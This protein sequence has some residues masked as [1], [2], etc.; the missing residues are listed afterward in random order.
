MD[1]M[2]YEFSSKMQELLE[3]ISEEQVRDILIALDMA[4]RIFLIGNGGSQAVCSH[5]ANDFFKRLYT[6]GFSLNSDALITCLANDYGFENMYVEWLQRF[7][8]TERDVVIAL[9]SSGRSPDITKVVDKLAAEEIDVIFICGFSGPEDTTFYE[10]LLGNFYLHFD[11]FNYGIVEM[12]T[13]VFLHALVEQLV[14]MEGD[15]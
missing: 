1:K 14:L 3:Q 15:E 9:S 2:L 10:E 4:E 8:L 5:I 12:T 6:P 7:D 11:N 13:E